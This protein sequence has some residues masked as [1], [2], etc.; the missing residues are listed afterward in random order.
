MLYTSS[1]LPNHKS[2][3]FPNFAS[4][5]SVMKDNSSGVF[6]VKCFILCPKGTNQSGNLK[7]SSA[8]VKIQQSVGTFETKNQFF[9]RV[10]YQS[11]VLWD[12]NSLW[13]FSLNSMYFQQKESLS[14]HKFGILHFDG[15]HLSKS[16]IKFQLKKYRRILSWHWRVMQSLKKTW[17][18]VSNMTWRIWWLFTQPF[19]RLNNYFEWTVFFQSVDGLSYKYT[20][21]L[22][23]MTLNRDTNVNKPC[24]CGFK[25]DLRNWVN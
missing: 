20:E 2:V 8:Q 3:I 12:I 1:H 14:R 5:I 15:F 25:S 7:I 18:V 10:L 11:L 19:R 13:F 24:R 21:E 17:P 6:L 23:F 16:Y 4:L 9:F 22:S